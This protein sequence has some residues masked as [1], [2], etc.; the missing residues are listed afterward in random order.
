M[1]S[2]N[3]ALNLLAAIGAIAILATQIGRTIVAITIVA[4]LLLAAPRAYVRVE[5]TD[6]PT[7][8]PDVAI[9]MLVKAPKALIRQNN[10]DQAVFVEVSQ[11]FWTGLPALV[12]LAFRDENFPN[13]PW[14]FYTNGGERLYWFYAAWTS[15]CQRAKIPSCFS[16]TRGDPLSATW[17]AQACPEKSPC[18]SQGTRRRTSIG[19]TSWR[20]GILPTRAHG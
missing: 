3:W 18:Q 10:K 20:N 5:P 1:Q 2:M 17:N 19:A 16:M 15:A 12:L 13:C 11:T 6:R 8:S 4:I 9:P 7:S 14:V